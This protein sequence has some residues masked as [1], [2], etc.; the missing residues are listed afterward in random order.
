MMGRRM[1]EIQWQKHSHSE[2]LCRNAAMIYSQG[3]DIGVMIASCDNDGF[4]G[5]SDNVN[6]INNNG[7]VKAIGSY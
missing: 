2:T 3:R 5:K 7:A 1:Q 6:I 4:C